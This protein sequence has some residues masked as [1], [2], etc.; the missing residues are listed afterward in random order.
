[1]KAL[2]FVILLGVALAHSDLTASSPKAG[3]RVRTWP[4]E[5]RLSFDEAV[6]L[7][8]SV[9]KVYPL[10]APNDAW[11]NLARLN[12]LAVPL[13]SQVLRASQDQSA[14]AD[15]GLRTT[16][17]TAKE[18]RLALKPG[19]KPGAYVVMWRALAIDTHTSSDFFVFVYAP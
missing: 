7:G 2:A 4:A 15:S 14:R 3:E 10:P 17:R 5:V 6:E 16:G 11:S 1:M 12:A 13:V 18:I 19:A 8:A 9:F